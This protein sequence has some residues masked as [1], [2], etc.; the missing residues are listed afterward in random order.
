MTLNYKPHGE[1]EW[2]FMPKHPY[3]SDVTWDVHGAITWELDEIL[4]Q[5]LVHENMTVD[6]QLVFRHKQT[7]E[8]VES[9]IGTV[10]LHK[11]NKVAEDESLTKV[12]LFKSH[13]SGTSILYFCP[14]GQ[15]WF[16]QERNQYAENRAIIGIYSFTFKGTYKLKK[17]EAG[18]YITLIT[19]F[20]SRIFEHYEYDSLSKTLLPELVKIIL[21]YVV[22][23]PSKYYGAKLLHLVSLNRVCKH[24]Y[25]LLTQIPIS[26]KGD[27]SDN[28]GPNRQVMY[29]TDESPLNFEGW[30]SEF[31]FAS[32][33]YY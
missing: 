30:L 25:N 22:S 31:R 28:Y 19:K 4:Y 6:W 18:H 12:T 24:W 23:P 2:Q 1:E 11:R 27:L 15:F 33:E 26:V 14:D 32:S 17:K 21:S 13:K 20:K 8:I 16:R 9:D 5:K 7:N 10:V 3:V 29:D